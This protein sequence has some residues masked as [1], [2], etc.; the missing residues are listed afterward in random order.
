MIKSHID[1]EVQRQFDI[2]KKGVVEIVPEDE[3]IAMLRIS[4]EKNRPLRVKCGID[5]TSRDV[6]IGH[7]IPYKKMR[8]FQDLGHRGIV[9]I[10]DY[11]ASIGDPTGRDEARPPLTA[12]EI[13]E[14]ADHY[15][16]Q[17]YKIVDSEKTDLLYQSK[18]FQD[19]HLQD[20]IKWASQTTVT[21]L[22]SHETFKERLKSSKPLFLHELLYPLLQGM[23]S[24][25]IKADVEL[26]ASD[27]KFNVLMGRDYQKSHGQRPQ[28]ALF[29]P[30]I[31]G[32]CGQKKMS[33]SLN[34]FVGIRDEPFDKFGK[35]MSIPDSI[36][37]EY[38]EFLI[39]VRGEELKKLKDGLFDKTLHPNEVKKSL[40]TQIVSF[41]HGDKIAASMRIK[42]EDIFKNKKAPKDIP[43]V[44]LTNKKTLTT[45]LFESHLVA[46]RS[47]ARRLI[48]QNA[49]K[50]IDGIRLI[51]P[52][53]ILDRSYS[54]KVIKIGKR[55]F[56][57]FQ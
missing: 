38:Y 5:P 35:I 41:F 40:A 31:T 26:G 17:V 44:T 1:K 21:K 51:D 14:N 25:Y 15:M 11:T 57:K 47:E 10:G 29:L 12:E 56:L 53:I 8:E 3:F 34:N 46:S 50:I 24:V 2:L 39:G 13:Q 18:W 20:I 32:L 9:I 22:L 33:K 7:S 30:L 54:G 36:M 55:R 19:I 6:H 45:L 43:T 23:D 48:Q 16:E 4:I 27:Q 42:F 28:V 49:V 52:E 37:M